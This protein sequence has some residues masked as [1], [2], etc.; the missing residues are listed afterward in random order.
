MDTPRGGFG[1][2]P[3]DHVAGLDDRHDTLIEE[4]PA[5]AGDPSPAVAAVPTTGVDGTDPTGFAPAAIPQ[6]GATAEPGAGATAQPGAGHIAGAEVPL[7]PAAV[8]PSAPA[9]VPARVTVARLVA[10]RLAAAGVR[11]AFG[12]PGEGSLA[13]PEELVEAGIRVVATRH[14]GAASFMAAA[15]AQLTGRPQVVFTSRTPGAANAAI[16]IHAARQDS[17]PVV[18]LLSGVRREHRGREA[19]QESD[20]ASG[21]GALARWSVE[22]ERPGDAARVLGEGFRQLLGGRPGP[23]ALV[24]PEDLLGNEVAHDAGWAPSQSSGVAP[25]RDAVRQTVK[26][27]AASRRGVILAGGGV[28]R[29]RASKRLLAFADELAIP[30]IASWR[31]PDLVPND[32]PGYL[33]MTGVWG[34]P[35]VRRRLE[36]A[37]VLLVLG[38]RLNQIATYGY[39]LP[40]PGTRW[41]HVDPEPRTAT[42]GLSAPDLAIASD[43]AR[44]LDLAWADLRGKVLDAENRAWRSERMAEDRAAF[45]AA[46][47]VAGGEWGGPGVHPGRVVATLQE[48]LPPNAILSTDA[49]TAVGWLARGYRFLRPGTFLGTTSGSMGYAIPAAVAASLVHGDRPVV[50]MCGDGGFSM[51]MAELETAVREGARPIVVVLDDRGYGAVRLQQDRQGRPRVASDLGPIDAASVAEACGALGFR[52]TDDAGFEMAFRD[53][54]AARR[55]AVIHCELDPAWVSVDRH[56]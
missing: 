9:S 15:A 34:A 38:A 56:P 3:G 43:P 10:Q 54:L 28:A 21:I 20:L 8:G 29:A 52:A 25:D 14:E 4:S 51:A 53:A 17:L 6:P 24:L 11:Y 13:I 19:F 36:E 22:L 48:A 37:D 2:G 39:R 32:H 46:S 44:F 49:G 40:A 12:V 31:R 18:A 33:G 27:L 50:A 23:I 5:A 7:T 35:T 55:A 30:I 47:E 45:L 16:G 42:R 26:W 1:G 41:V